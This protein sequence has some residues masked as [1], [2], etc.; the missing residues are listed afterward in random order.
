MDE[1]QLFSTVFYRVRLFSIVSMF[2]PDFQITNNILQQIAEIEASK[3]IIENA[4]LVPAWERRFKEEAV[5]RQV[6]HSTAIEGNEL[7]YTEAKDLVEGKKIDS[8]RKRDVQEILNYRKAISFIS[9]NKKYELTLD[10]ILSLN[11]T[12]LADIMDA[13][14]LGKLREKGVVIMS[15][16]TQD[17][18][19]EPPS[20]K[21]IGS[22]IED[23]LD[24]Y[25]KD[26]QAVN[27]ILVSGIL[28][29]EVARIHPFIEGNGRTARLLSTWSLY[30]TGYDIKEFFSLDEYY[31]QD[32]KS[33]YDALASADDGELTKWLEYF[34][35]GLGEELSRVKGKILDISRDVKLRKTAGQVALSDRQI[36]LIQFMEENESLQNRDWKTLLPD[37]SDDTILRDLKD[38]IDKKVVKKGGRTKA[39]KYQLI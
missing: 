4:P 1:L 31:D 9:S 32:A 16:K 15:S 35:R 38:L 21:E 6:H 25:N 34:T 22:E 2:K 7:N 39:A 36:K 27:P 24:W 33:Y 5:I 30:V 29:H 37:V 17:V 19:M 8:M 18:V 13:G 3:Q 28:Q 12:L 20:G 23:L 14:E 10:F 11:K 26:S